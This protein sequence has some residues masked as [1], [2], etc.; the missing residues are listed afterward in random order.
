AAPAQARNK[1]QEQEQEQDKETGSNIAGRQR[2]QNKDKPD[3]TQPEYRSTNSVV[4]NFAIYLTKN[5]YGYGGQGH[6]TAF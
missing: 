2:K 6:S 5:R 1:E 3:R 4:R